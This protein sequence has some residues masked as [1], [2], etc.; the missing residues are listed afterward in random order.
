KKRQQFLDWISKLD[1]QATQMQKF[2]QHA[3]QTGG[4]FLKRQEFFDRKDGKT[5]LLWCP[6]IPGAGKTILL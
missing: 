6:G 2:E 4:W 5:K 3:A 1:F